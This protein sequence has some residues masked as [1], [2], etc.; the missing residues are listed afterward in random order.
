M[1]KSGSCPLSLVGS[2]IYGVSYEFSCL[3][4]DRFPKRSAFAY[5][6]GGRGNRALSLGQRATANGGCDGVRNRRGGRS[7]P[8]RDLGVGGVGFGVMFDVG[9]GCFRGV[10]RCMLLVAMG[11]MRVMCCCLVLSGFMVASGFPVVTSRVFV[12]LCC[13]VM[14]LC[15][16]LGHNFPPTG[17]KW[18]RPVNLR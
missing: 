8:C 9:L 4:R 2:F 1:S 7:P 5:R 3:C 10:M 16:L 14:M 18:R 15:C 13:L 17:R 12:M 11:H 6:T